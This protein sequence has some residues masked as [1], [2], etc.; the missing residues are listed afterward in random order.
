MEVMDHQKNINDTHEKLLEIQKSK[1]F[2]EKSRF[3]KNMIE[4]DGKYS[5]VGTLT[6]AT[7]DGVIQELIQDQVISKVNVKNHLGLLDAKIQEA[8]R[9]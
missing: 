8:R 5:N 9:R 4:G 1:H 7:I 6:F 3:V 2:S